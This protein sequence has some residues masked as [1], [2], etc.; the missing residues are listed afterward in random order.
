M[1]LSNLMS[2]LILILGPVSL[3]GDARATK[4]AVKQWNGSIL[5]GYVYDRTQRDAQAVGNRSSFL[6]TTSKH[7]WT[8]GGVVTAPL[9]RA[10]GARLLFAVGQS[11][12]ERSGAPSF[13]GTTVDAD[14]IDA[15]AVLFL[16][17]PELGHLDLGYRFRWEKPSGLAIER[18]MTNTVTLD[19]GF[20]IA[21][22]GLGP[23]DWDVSLSYGRVSSRP[24]RI[25][26]TINEYT[27]SGAM[28]YYIG[29]SWRVS[30]GVRWLLSDPAFDGSTEDLRGTA[31]L[32]W[33]LPVTIAKRRFVTIDLWGTVGRV[34]T[35][36]PGPLP[37]ASRGAFSAGLDL[38]FSYPGAASLI[39]LIR[40]QR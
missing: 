15:A 3:A 13:A 23:V 27:V 6:P 38:T 14:R 39:E 40:E 18:E 34:R 33:L 20:Y 16:R 1:L 24:S 21:D 36:L 12:T 25:T 19:A 5:G 9:Y 28:S 10:L 30:G 8:L 11:T 37:S 22:Q 31:E 7:S 32:S 26:Q 2:L 4:P 17:D 29:K 35:E